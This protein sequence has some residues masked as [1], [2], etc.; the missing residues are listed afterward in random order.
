MIVSDRYPNTD[1]DHLVRGKIEKRS[2]IG[3]V[4]GHKYEK[5][6]PPACHG[7]VFRD[8][9]AFTADAKTRCFRTQIQALFACQRQYGVQLGFFHESIVGRKAKKPAAQFFGLA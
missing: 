9:K 8:D 2:G 7:A 5:A 3:S 1:L 4:A 6:R